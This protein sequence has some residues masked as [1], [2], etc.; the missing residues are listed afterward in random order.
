MGL[1]N[2]LNKMK[3]F[4]FDEVEDKEEKKESKREKRRKKELEEAFDSEPKFEEPKVENTFDYDFDNDYVA[5]TTENDVIEIT[6]SR[7]EKKEFKVPDLTDDDFFFPEKEPVVEPEPIIEQKPLLYQGSKRK[8]ETRKFKPSPNISPV[9]G[10][11]DENG[12]TINDEKQITDTF[13][14]NDDESSLDAVRKK[15]YGNLDEELENTLKRLSGK[16][17]E[18]AEKEEL[19]ESLSREKKKEKK[20]KKIK[21]EMVKEEKV[22]EEKDEPDEEDEMILPSVSF[23]E[24]DVDKANEVTDDEDDEETKEQDLFNLIDTMYSKE[25]DE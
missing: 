23:K 4:L 10:L 1:K 18:E 9:Y 3:S 11:L 8:E 2:R 20:A 22:E 15:A 19:D 5:P 17:I 13:S 12:N 6:K 24:I 7:T 16:T 25:D 21:E 14:N